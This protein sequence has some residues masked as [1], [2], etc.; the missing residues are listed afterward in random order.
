MGAD[1]A[2]LIIYRRPSWQD[3]IRAYQVRVDGVK[4]G[5][6]R[7]KGQLVVVVPAGEHEIV[8]KISWKRT[9]GLR[10]NLRPGQVQRVYVGPGPAK[11]LAKAYGGFPYLVLIPEPLS[12]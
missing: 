5:R 4:V 10:L 6:V 1:V 7:P 12:E 9:P 8:A 11:P 3:R 2:Q